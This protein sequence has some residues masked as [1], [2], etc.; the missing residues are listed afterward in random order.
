MGDL[1]NLQ[2]QLAAAAGTKDR[3]LIILAEEV[4]RGDAAVAKALGGDG[5]AVAALLDSE[6]SSADVAR[7]A[8]AE[9]QSAGRRILKARIDLMRAEFLKY[10][11]NLSKIYRSYLGGG[12]SEAA[13]AAL[14]ELKRVKG[15]R[16]ASDEAE[17][18]EAAM[19]E[20]SKPKE[21]AGG[22]LQIA[23]YAD[24]KRYAL[25]GTRI[26]LVKARSRRQLH[27]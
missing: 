24:G 2:K 22:W 16:E 5:S 23:R 15:M 11:G 3:D 4:K 25:K 14:A 20:A 18:R 13:A 7:V 12:D 27:L 10:E 6:N 26:R 8:R 17:Q 21:V 19:A 1:R 9:F